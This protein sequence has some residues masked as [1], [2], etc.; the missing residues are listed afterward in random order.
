MVAK[1][2]AK[3]ASPKSEYI[4]INEINDTMVTNQDIIKNLINNYNTKMVKVGKPGNNLK[5][6]LIRFGRKNR[7]SLQSKTTE[8]RHQFSS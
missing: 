8:N 6:K 3:K 2:K 7:Q 5:S 4:D 1:T